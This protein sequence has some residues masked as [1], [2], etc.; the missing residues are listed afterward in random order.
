MNYD[1]F[2]NALKGGFI[3]TIALAALMAG[4]KKDDSSATPSFCR[5]TSVSVEYVSDNDNYQ[6]QTDLTFNADGQ[7]IKEGDEF[8]YEWSDHTLVRRNFYDGVL[9]N[10]STFMLDGDGRAISETNVDA[11]QNL[12]FNRTYQY[13]AN[14]YLTSLS[15]TGSYPYTEVHEWVN[16]NLSKTTRTTPF[17]DVITS[18]YTYDPQLVTPASYTVLPIL[19]K[20]SKNL[21]IYSAGAYSFGGYWTTTD[22]QY[23]LDQYGN[24]LKSIVNLVD[25]GVASTLTLEYLYE[26]CQ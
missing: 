2:S 3:G 18:T 15:Q 26:G 25:T 1:P 9:Q 24:V 17:G 13:D 10:K 23:E 19:G 14:G 4:C 8:T 6:Y 20:V 11:G 16:G 22:I 12:V 7:L 21:V 5:Q